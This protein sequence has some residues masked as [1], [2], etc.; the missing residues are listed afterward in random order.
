MAAFCDH[1]IHDRC[2]GMSSTIFYFWMDNN[3]EFCRNLQRVRLLPISSRQDKGLS[4]AV[5]K[6]LRIFFQKRKCRTV[7]GFH[8]TLI[9]KTP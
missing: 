7:T 3:D 1:L 8:D 4:V 6:E 2:T 9:Q 5:N